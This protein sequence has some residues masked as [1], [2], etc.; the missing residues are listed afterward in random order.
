MS[1]SAF[2]RIRIS[3]Q[4]LSAAVADYQLLLG[5]APVWQ[6]QISFAE[7]E[8]ACPAAWFVLNNT[9]LELLQQT[10]HKSAVI[11][12]VLTSDTIEPTGSVTYHSEGGEAY[13]SA[14][15]LIDKAQAS[16]QWVCLQGTDLQ[17]QL[18]SVVN[19]HLPED[20]LHSVDHVV[21]YTNDADHCIRDF[22]DDGLGIRLALDKRV[23]EWG[24][25]MLFF[26]AGKLTLEVIE[27]NERFDGDDYFWGIAYQVADLDAVLSRLQRRGV[28]TSAARDG[29][30]PGTRV[31]TVKSHHFNIPTLLVQPAIKR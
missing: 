27:P 10:D 18:A 17:L 2:Q 21:L 9:I 29:R 26:R 7:H 11:G 6:G 14:E 8:Q 4:S 16:G 28:T 15:Q 23:P 31:A 24:G 20:C 3:C 5:F 12:L 1:V 13:S 19:D 30:K 25:R 22:A